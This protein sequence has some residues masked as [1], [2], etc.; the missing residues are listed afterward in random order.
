M[1]PSAAA[2]PLLERFAAY[3]PT[4]ADEWRS[5]PRLLAIIGGYLAVSAVA[6]IFY[7]VNGGAV[8]TMGYLT[9]SAL[10][11][12]ALLVGARMHRP[13]SAWPWAMLA[14]GQVA[15]L[16]GG[17]AWLLGDLNG[18]VPYPSWAGMLYL[19]GYPLTAAGLALFILAQR[20]QFGIARLV[21]AAAIG[22]GC[23]V[24]LA[25]GYVHELTT[26][27]ALATAGRLALLA[28]PVFDAL[29]LAALAYLMLTGGAWHARAQQALALSIGLLL[30]A[31]AVYGF[32]LSDSN[33]A[34]T[35]VD[36]LWLLSYV[37]IGLAALLPSMRQLTDSQASDDEG[38]ASRAMVGLLAIA[39][40]VAVADLA[41]ESAANRPLAGELVE[42]GLVALLLLR[43]YQSSARE[44][45]RERRMAALLTNASD[46]LAVL[47]ADG[48]VLFSNPAAERMFGV[49]NE[50]SSG[51]SALDF[52][53]LAHPDDQATGAAWMA[54][55]LARS[56][57]SD[58]AEFRV[59]GTDGRYRWVA[60]TASN[61]LADP[62][63]GGVVLHFRD[64]T[65]GHFAA[66]R[67][68]RLAA[69]VEQADEAVVIS[70]PAGRI[71]YVNPAFE[72]MT[73]YAAAE[74]VGENPRLLKS[75]RQPASF[76]EMMWAT[77]TAGQPWI[78]DFVNR[79]KDGSEY[80]S[81]AVISSIRG[82]DGTITGYVGVS[83]D[84]TAERHE[85]A[86]AAQLARERALITETIRAIDTRESA[87]GMAGA[88]CN[89]VVNLPDVATSALV[90]FELDGRAIPYGIVSSTGEQL[91]RRRLPRARV[92]EVRAQ[93]DKGPWI[94][95]WHDRPGHPYNELLVS[96]GVKAVAYAPIR[97]GDQVFGYL[98]ISSA[99]DHAEEALSAAMPAL[100]ELADVSAALIGP[101]VAEHTRAEEVRQRVANIIDRNAFI[102]V[103]QP[104]VD[105]WNDRVVG[106]EAL[107]RFANGNAPD[108]QFAEA[109]AAG[110]GKQLELA[111][112]TQAIAAA[113]DL[114][115]GAW[116]NVNASPALV[117]GGNGFA[118]L[119]LNSE[120]PLVVELT[121]HELVRDYGQF[122]AAMRR[123]GPNVR[124]AVDD[125]GAGFASLRHIL[126]LQPSFVKLDRALTSNIGDDKA[127]QALVAGMKHFAR[128]AGFW[129]IAEGV[130]TEAE[131][132]ALRELDIHYA[133]GFLLGEPQPISTSQQRA[134]AGRAAQ[135]ARTPDQDTGRS[136]PVRLALP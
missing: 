132:Q 130:E 10:A 14:I 117:L 13:A 78:A 69:A 105:I 8:G 102:P 1:T 45:L 113:R 16:G 81:S 71:E 60:V 43:A 76:Y 133:Q 86:R 55:V 62:A 32:F 87:E 80:Q 136:E 127:R 79:R 6:V 128:D 75:G 124:L 83:R 54:K 114:P 112:T 29:V 2:A 17:V 19:A 97:N 134:S 21:D 46:A 82:S 30:A 31:D 109:T 110:M 93:A 39:A 88:I 67:L 22:L 103:F 52:M 91:P 135:P 121:E 72:R 101:K 51:R 100:V 94:E 63:V 84:V 44:A 47:A 36:G 59:C 73:G 20:P 90:I 25:G 107:T 11:P 50:R 53:G 56:N 57:S 131:L 4:L 92:E 95:A 41:N 37:A 89:R 96:R 77:L 74:A 115:A 38:S 65:E 28:Y 26:N 34:R 108:E 15:F 42:V 61:R 27:P 48:R 120:R 23:A 129:I 9:V 5:Q 3:R 7:F 64:V 33:Y 85:E 126:E 24:L 58:S 122:R 106:F 12:V 35:T 125:A 123:L 111:A 98:L 18:I 70:D 116:L 104:I 68:A 66:E 119:V 118:Q 40:L 49:A 99:A